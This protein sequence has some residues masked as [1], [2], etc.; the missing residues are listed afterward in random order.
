MNIWRDI[1]VKIFHK[2][3]HIKY[4]GDRGRFSFAVDYGDVPVGSINPITGKFEPCVNTRGNAYAARKRK[5]YRNKQV[6]QTKKF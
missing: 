2:F 4:I 1:P 6:M 5:M 3:H